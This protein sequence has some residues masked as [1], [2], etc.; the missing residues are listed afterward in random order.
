M[1]L[2][3]LNTIL[4]Q[5]GFPVAYSHFGKPQKPPFIT[6]VVAYSSNFGADDKV[7]Q[8]IENVQIELYTDKKDLE[9]EERIKAVLD[10]NSLYYETTETY[11]PSERLYQKVYEVRLL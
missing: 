8:D 10:A 11:I 2:D 4:K 3:E 1:N 5:T 9:A 6:Y 7:Y